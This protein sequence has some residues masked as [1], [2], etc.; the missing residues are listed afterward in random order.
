[1]ATDHL[2]ESTHAGLAHAIIDAGDRTQKFGITVTN[3]LTV[4]ASK[5]L[6]AH[7]L[8]DLTA[9]ID[10]RSMAATLERK[11]FDAQLE[12]LLDF[13]EAGLIQWVRAVLE[14]SEWM[15][16]PVATTPDDAPRE[17]FRLA[18][19]FGTILQVRLA[20]ALSTYITR[21]GLAPLP[22]AEDIGNA[23][24][25]T[26]AKLEL[27]D[28]FRLDDCLPLLRDLIP[29]DA[30][31][32]PRDTAIHLAALRVLSEFARPE[33]ESLFLLYLTNARVALWCFRT[34]VAIDRRHRRLYWRL[35]TTLQRD[36]RLA[37]GEAQGL[38]EIFLGDLSQ[39]TL[40]EVGKFVQPHLAL[41]PDVLADCLKG[42]RRALAHHQSGIEITFNSS[43]AYG[44]LGEHADEEFRESAF[45]CLTLT[46]HS[47]NGGALLLPVESKETMTALA[48][49]FF[50][51]DPEPT[52]DDV[53]T[54]LNTPRSRT[55]L[56]QVEYV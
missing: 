49:T 13:D 46:E 53:I 54:L 6:T 48:S 33:D 28:L 26:E 4:R 9:Q 11:Y 19:E 29:S 10:D 25:L 42:L 40:E 43:R 27:I 34:L 24:L 51:P 47:R 52:M 3:D 44:A 12:L 1:M 37:E 31:D 8:V 23:T 20:S 14:E 55:Q 30:S 21:Y 39:R 32:R 41:A 17:M 16:V 56:R 38:A 22:Q 45:A 50:H 2:F 36:G 15:P 7:E 35:I 18:L 5:P